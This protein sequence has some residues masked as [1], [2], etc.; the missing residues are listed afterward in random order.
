MNQHDQ[1][2]HL[3][4]R[5]SAH[6]SRSGPTIHNLDHQLDTSARTDVA[7]TTPTLDDVR[8]WAATVD[9][10][11]AAT[12]FGISRSH[13]YD[14]IARGEFPAKVIQLGSTYRVLTASIVQVLS[15]EADR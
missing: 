11:R 8:S 10:A 12:A 2:D 1:Q 5:P 4:A 3:Q 9:V 14:L 15:G 6:S 13:A 7:G